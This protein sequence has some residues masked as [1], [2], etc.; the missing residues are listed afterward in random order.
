MVR[1]YKTHKTLADADQFGR[2]I[3]VR[4]SESR[5]S[6]RMLTGMEDSEPCKGLPVGRAAPSA[7][8]L[9]P[10]PWRLEDDA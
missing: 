9:T 5:A 6:F 10:V 2:A 7:Q 4:A 1:R 3:A 8:R